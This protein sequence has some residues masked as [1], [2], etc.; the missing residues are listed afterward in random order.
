MIAFQAHL[1]S[2][3]FG[4]VHLLSNN[5]AFP[6]LE[7]TLYEV[8]NVSVLFTAIVLVLDRTVLGTY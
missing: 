7:Y 5:I 4:H 8:R 2:E 1:A 6:P 3:S